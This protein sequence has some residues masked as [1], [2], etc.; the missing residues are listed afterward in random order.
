[1]PL[2]ELG[3]E[4]GQQVGGDGG[5]DTQVEGAR[6]RLLLFGHDVL[7]AGGFGQYVPGLLQDEPSGGRRLHR[8]AGAVEEAGV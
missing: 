8:L 1:M 4:A 5:Q 3:E 7:E 2:H 6:Q